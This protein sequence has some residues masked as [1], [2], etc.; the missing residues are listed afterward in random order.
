[1]NWGNLDV[2]EGSVRHKIAAV[3]E[4]Q[5][6]MKVRREIRT[7]SCLAAFGAVC[8]VIMALDITVSAAEM[9]FDQFMQTRGYATVAM[10]H[11]NQN[12]F[13][14]D[15]ILNG[16]YVKCLVDTGAGFM[17][18]DARKG[19]EMK[20]VDKVKAPV[21]TA[22]GSQERELQKVALGR[23]QLGPVVYTNLLAVVA[24]LHADRQVRTGSFIP[25][26]T[27]YDEFDLVLG[28][29]FLRSANATIECQKPALYVRPEPLSGVP[30][31]DFEAS[32]KVSGFSWV[33]FVHGMNPA[34]EAEVNGKKALFRLDTGI[35]ATAL[36]QRLIRK[37]DLVDYRTGGHL[38][39]A[40][41]KRR[42]LLFTKVRS[43]K[44]A[45]FD[46]GP[47]PVGVSDFEDLRKS[48]DE[49]AKAGQPPMIG[50]L[51]PEI[52]YRAGALIDC[53]ARRV[54]VRPAP[55]STK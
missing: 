43:I 37:F 29:D 55:G 28:M 7:P 5:P 12:R 18:I 25:S 50:Y 33:P 35:T 36:D 21:Q 10:K 54:Y 2:D 27:S 9:T 26:A 47:M 11:G 39:D 17:S 45:S 23:L 3:K 19:M 32:L 20:L 4:D 8:L 6:L 44:L 40:A 48:V 53:S 30:A 22:F 24:Q 38:V 1:M 13:Y 16:Q 46:S 49:L 31:E 41:Q 52:L 15:G 51:G 34:V 14:A 42:E